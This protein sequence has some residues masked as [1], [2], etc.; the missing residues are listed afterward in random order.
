MFA[1]GDQ[2]LWG[3]ASIVSVCLIIF[4]LSLV[5]CTPEQAPVAT[6]TP[7]LPTQ[8]SIPTKPPTFTV[9]PTDIPTSTPMNS[10][11][12][13]PTETLTPLPTD[14][15]TSTITPANLISLSAP[16]DPESFEAILTALM[17]EMD[18]TQRDTVVENIQDTK[19]ISQC[20]LVWVETISD[21]QTPTYLVY[22]S[23]IA[24]DEDS[25]MVAIHPATSA[26]DSLGNG[27]LGVTLPGSE[28][29]IL[30]TAAYRPPAGVQTS[31]EFEI[32]VVFSGCEVYSVITPWP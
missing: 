9:T 12:P 1:K 10:P 27:I 31:D 21:A 32:Q 29:N 17:F 5:A 24:P 30:M 25:F 16:P 14:T 20:P 3:L 2:S 6:S 18:K 8:T 15:P 19:P 28:G 26:M 13:P 11:I 22:I 7:P 4:V 23:M